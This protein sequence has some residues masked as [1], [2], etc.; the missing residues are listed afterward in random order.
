MTK[1]YDALTQG[2]NEVLDD[3]KGKKSTLRRHTVSIEIEPVPCYS[4]ENIKEIRNKMRL[5][6]TLFAKYFGVSIKTV[7]AW[8]AGRNKPSGPSSRLLSLLEIHGLDKTIA[9]PKKKYKTNRN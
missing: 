7:E 9:E 3:V 6:Q 2:L 1:V 4:A 5:S 8:E